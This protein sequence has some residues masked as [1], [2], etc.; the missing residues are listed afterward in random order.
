MIDSQKSQTATG[1]DTVAIQITHY[2][3]YPTIR[4]DPIPAVTTQVAY[5][6]DTKEP[7]GFSRTLQLASEKFLLVKTKFDRMRELEIIRF[8]VVLGPLILIWSPSP[9]VTLREL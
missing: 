7:P 3:V 2:D 1:S 6:T 8:P 4:T 9:L 5:R